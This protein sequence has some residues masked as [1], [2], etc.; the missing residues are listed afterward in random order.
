MPSPPKRAMRLLSARHAELAEDPVEYQEGTR[1]QSD[2]HRHGRVLPGC[3]LAMNRGRRL[4]SSLLVDQTTRTTGGLVD[5][6]VASRIVHPRGMQL[7][8]VST[9]FRRGSPE[10]TAVVVVPYFQHR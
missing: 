3:S 5:T 10:A 2:S 9:D 4:T 8:R 1:R 6:G 7:P